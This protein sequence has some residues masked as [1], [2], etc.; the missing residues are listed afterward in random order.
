MITCVS[1]TH[2][3]ENDILLRWTDRISLGEENKKHQQGMKE[4]NEFINLSC[5][6]SKHIC[7]SSA[8]E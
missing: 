8:K 6:C 1:N 5:T 7:I 4:Y 2:T 3:L